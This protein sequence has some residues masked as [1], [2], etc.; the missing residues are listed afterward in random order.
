MPRWR[1]RKLST[2]S[3]RIST[4]PPAASKTRPMASVPGGV[5][6][7][8]APSASTPFVAGEL[9]GEVD[10]RRLAALAAGPRRCRRT[11]PTFA[12]GTSTTPASCS[13]SATPGSSA[14]AAPLLGQVVERGERVRLAAAEL[15]DERQHRRGVV[16]PA[17]QPAQ[18]H[19]G[20]LAQRPREAGA[21][22]ELVG[23][24]VVLRGRPG[25]DLFQVDGE[26]VR[27]ERPAFADFLARRR[28]PYTRAPRTWRIPRFVR[29]HTGPVVP[30]DRAANA[31][32]PSIKASR[33]GSFRPAWYKSI[34]WTISSANSRPPSVG[35]WPLRFTASRNSFL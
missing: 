30:D 31:L 8:A 18:H 1:L 9:A 24:P 16:G 4:Q 27:V 3:K 34:S 17:R 33:L 23:L 20:V 19:P 26:L 28:R 7:A 6:F 25:D 35:S 13:R 21:G 10:P 22:E 2:S 32:S 5:V 11:P 12:F 15:G 29:L 14:A